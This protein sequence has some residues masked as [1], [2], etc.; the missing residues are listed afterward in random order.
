MRPERRLLLLT[1]FLF[2]IVVIL[3]VIIN[4][5]RVHKMD[6][7]INSNSTLKLTSQVFAEGANIPAQYSCKGQNVNPPL[8][9]S[10][11]PP[12]AKS[13]ALIVHDPD[14]VS[15]DYVH[16]LMWDIPITTESIVVNSVPTGAVQGQNGSGANKYVG[17]CPPAGTG[18]HHYMFELYALDS[19]LANLSQTTDRDQLVKAMSGHIVDKTILTGLFAAD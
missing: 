1:G 12:N 8:N 19:P 17:P 3:G 15:G 9:F 10:G 11:V 7:S 6:N 2:L 14:A 13:L 5:N 18:V 4:H 16:W